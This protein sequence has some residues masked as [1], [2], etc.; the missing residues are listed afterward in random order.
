MIDT[1]VFSWSGCRDILAANYILIANLKK[2]IHKI[3]HE[4]IMCFFIVNMCYNYIIL[5]QS[6][7]GTYNF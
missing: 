4:K 1:H 3:D 5:V 7:L 6:K 2:K